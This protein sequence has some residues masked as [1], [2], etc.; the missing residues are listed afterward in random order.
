MKDYFEE[1]AQEVKD[2]EKRIPLSKAVELA[3]NPP[4]EKEREN[5]FEI[6]N[7]LRL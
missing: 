7:N 3:Y 4:E 1:C 5:M 6:L 2:E